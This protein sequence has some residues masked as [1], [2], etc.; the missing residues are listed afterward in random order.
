MQTPTTAGKIQYLLDRGMTKKEIAQAIK[1]KTTS[2]ITRVLNGGSPYTGMDEKIDDVIMETKKPLSESYNN[3]LEESLVASEVFAGDM[4]VSWR[5][6]LLAVVL[7][8]AV[9]L[10]FA[11]LFAWIGGTI[12]LLIIGRHLVAGL[13]FMVGV[14]LFGNVIKWW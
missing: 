8:V 12:W 11:F 5:D 10:V 7:I 4:S 14:L 3:Q 2:P 1:Y 9:L 13:W 6:W